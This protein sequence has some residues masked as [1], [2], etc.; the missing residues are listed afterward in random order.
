MLINKNSITFRTLFILLATST[1]FILFMGSTAHYIF[2]NGYKKIIAEKIVIIEQN[3]IP[4]VALN[5][6]YG[7]KSA[8]DE[9]CNN[10]LSNPDI[11]LIKV[12]SKLLKNTL[13]YRSKSGEK[14]LQSILST[15]LLTDPATSKPIGKFTIVYSNNEYNIYM[16]EFHSIL[17]YGVLIFL[18]AL[19]F[20]GYY[21][22]KS[23]KNLE[24]LAKELESFN[25]QKPQR[26][27][28]KIDSKDEV[29]SIALSANVMITNI[30]KYIETSKKLNN[31]LLKN[32]QTIEHLAYYDAL[33]KLPNR[34]LLKDRIKQAINSAKREKNKVAVI[35]LDLDH[36]KLINDTLG[37]SIG[38]KLLMYVSKLL[39]QQIREMDTVARIGGDEFVILMPNIKSWEDAE[40]IAKKLL[41]SLQ[42][43]HTI[44][45]HQLYITTSIGISIFPDT[46]Q[47]LDELVTNADTAMYDAKQD[48]RN[49]YKIYSRDMGNYISTQMSLEQDLKKAISNG[50]ELELYYQAKIDTKSKKIS[51]A[52]ALIRWNHHE[53]GLLFPDEFIEIAESTGMILE[54]G[55][56]IIVQAIK[57]LKEWNKKG[58]RDL[59]IAINLSPRQ[60]LDKNLVKLISSLIEEHDID[61]SQLEFEITETMSMSNIEATLRTLKNLKN[62]GV[63]IA[64]DDFGTGYSSLSY[65][66]K[67]PVHTLKIDKSFVMD[68][69]HDEE[70]RAIVETIISMAHTLGFKTVAE[71]VETVEHTELLTELGCD[72]LQGYYYSKA[73]RKD[74]FTKFLAQ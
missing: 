28:M 7:F 39:S 15:S 14:N 72:Y 13:V 51:G 62:L 41:E 9:I 56:W 25:P 6:S 40:L 29:A 70:D 32:R 43:Q 30:I 36:F 27:E 8:I 64:I 37:H 17:F 71:G 35:F 68:M 42:G 47:S 53:K 49:R 61:P 46:A 52:E 45:G 24:I 12:E 48:G 18:V 55:S 66:K 4:S 59:K 74:E 5:L 73:I 1:L 60:F 69:T 31:K 19:L 2:S 63:T 65:L 26:L 22:Y 67:F 38:D 34:I 58:Y 11:L 3:I 54:M 10:S 20:V 57:D 44:E 16:K 21:I 50:D 33:T 23:L